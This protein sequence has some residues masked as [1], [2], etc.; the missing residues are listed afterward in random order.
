MVSLF[1]MPYRINGWV[2][3]TGW[4]LSLLLCFLCGCV[5]FD[6]LLVS[7]LMWLFRFALSLLIRCGPP[8]V[9]TRVYMYHEGRMP[10]AGRA[11]TECDPPDWSGQ[12]QF[13]VF[14][15]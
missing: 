11:P 13:D 15:C 9:G 6:L 2:V 8:R 1:A 5:Y 4:L 7:P 3:R 10:A 12:V 14:G